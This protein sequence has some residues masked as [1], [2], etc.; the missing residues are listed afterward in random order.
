MDIIISF[1]L[2]ERITDRQH[3]R[4]PQQWGGHEVYMEDEN[5]LGQAKQVGWFV[6]IHGE[7]A[8]Q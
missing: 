5:E 1:Y 2:G 3:G 7:K 8:I 6:D 4:K